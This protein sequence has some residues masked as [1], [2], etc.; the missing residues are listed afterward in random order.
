ME[1]IPP[2]QFGFALSCN[3][4]LQVPNDNGKM[5]MYDAYD[6]V[7]FLGGSKEPSWVAQSKS[8]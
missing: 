7:W 8:L 2:A 5:N 4:H 3:M 6:F 1:P